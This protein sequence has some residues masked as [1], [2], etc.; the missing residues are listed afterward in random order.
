MSSVLTA[1]APIFAL[2]LL[3]YG[4]KHLKI[5]EDAFW[6]PAEHLTY[7]VLFPALLLGSVAEADLSG[8]PIVQ[9]S[10]AQ[11]LAV[12]VL[13]AATATIGLF[14]KTVDGPSFSSVFQGVQ[15]PNTYVA[16]AAGG[17]LYGHSGIALAAFCATIMVPMVNVFS[18]I[19]MIHWAHPKEE[20]SHRGKLITKAI[21]TNPLILSCVLGGLL[22]WTGVGLTP[23][24]ASTLKILGQA[25][26]TLGLLVVGAGINLTAIHAQRWPLLVSSIGKLAGLPLLVGLFA[27]LMGVTSMPLEIAVM[28]ASVPTSASSYVM[29]RQLNGDADLMAAIITATTLVA[30]LTMPIALWAMR[31]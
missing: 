12:I 21:F 17:G 27:T 19:G 22:N 11:A 16:L 5:I 9:L 3:G 13:L 15:R 2:I 26:L 28:Y 29:A 4:L 23:V 8:M 14:M 25:S 18:T 7:W 10:I 24:L 1:L 6:H 30:A 31:G 20:G